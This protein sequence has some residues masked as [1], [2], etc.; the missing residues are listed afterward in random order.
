MLRRGS[1]RYASQREVVRLSYNIGLP[2]KIGYKAVFDI[3]G[4]VILWRII[5]SVAQLIPAWGKHTCR[6]VD[7]TSMNEE[8][9]TVMVDH[10]VC[11][12]RFLT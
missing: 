8:C 7:G 9:E 12:V 6:P 10:Q 3:V 2:D 11:A 5:M 1:V 4:K